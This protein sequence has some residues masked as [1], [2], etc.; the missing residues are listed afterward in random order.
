MVFRVL[1]SSYGVDLN[2]EAGK[3]L[4]NSAC[5]CFHQ[6]SVQFPKRDQSR[7]TR[8][9]LQELW[10]FG[11]ID[12]AMRAEEPVL[13]IKTRL[14]ASIIYDCLAILRSGKRGKQAYFLAKANAATS[15]GMATSQEPT[16]Q[17]E[18]LDFQGKIG[19]FDN[20]LADYLPLPWNLEFN[21][22]DF[23]Y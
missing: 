20:L 9:I 19:G 11:E 17:S 4:Y 18:D 1:H 5:L 22:S 7:R 15:S 2:Y 13:S 16:P 21:D 14:G 3:A 6:Q 8:D 23:M 12:T 10:R